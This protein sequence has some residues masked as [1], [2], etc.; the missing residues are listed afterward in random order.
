MNT[1]QIVLITASVVVSAAVL[2]LYLMYGDKNMSTERE[3]DAEEW[4]TYE[5]PP[6]ELRFSE[7]EGDECK[8]VATGI[9]NQAMNHYDRQ[10]QERTR[11]YTTWREI[12]GK[13]RRFDVTLTGNPKFE[14]LSKFGWQFSDQNADGNL[15]APEWS[16]EVAAVWRDGKQFWQPE[17]WEDAMWLLIKWRSSYGMEGFYDN[18]AIVISPETYAMCGERTQRQL[19]YLTEMIAVLSDD[20]LIANFYPNLDSINQWITETYDPSFVGDDTIGVW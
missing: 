6:R 15:P 18:E 17:E 8:D 13:L 19:E 1:Q 9:Y 5:K 7:T 11:L 10:V 4:L 3:F 2:G 12:T 14:A 16:D 20:D